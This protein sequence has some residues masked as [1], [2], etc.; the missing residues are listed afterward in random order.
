MKKLEQMLN[1]LE[2]YIYIYTSS[3]TSTS[4][5]TSISADFFSCSLKNEIKLNVMDSTK[6]TLALKCKCFK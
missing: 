3:I 4:D 1:H 5:A 6:F 2:I